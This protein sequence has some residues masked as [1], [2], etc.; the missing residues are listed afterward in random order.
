MARIGRVG[1]WGI[2]PTHLGTLAQEGD[3]LDSVGRR[4]VGNQTVLRDSSATVRTRK[5]RAC[6]LPDG[7]M[8]TAELAVAMV[9]LSIV[10]A[11]LVGGVAVAMAHVKAQEAARAGARAAARGDTVGQV[12]NTARAALPGAKVR[13]SGS[14]EQVK[15]EVVS[16]ISVPLLGRANL[17][18]TSTAVADREPQ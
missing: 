17:K 5:V 6:A 10:V 1:G 2:R 12:R 3:G 7:G 14:S 15:V 18:V 8:A 4:I 11:M 16:V 9:A 13:V